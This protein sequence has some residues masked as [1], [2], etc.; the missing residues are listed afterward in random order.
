[1]TVYFH[2]NL[3]FRRKNKCLKKATSPLKKCDGVTLIYIKILKE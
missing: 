3:L 2:I 1:M